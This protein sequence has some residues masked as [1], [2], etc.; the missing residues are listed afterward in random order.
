MIMSIEN[1][2]SRLKNVT[3]IDG[4][5]EGGQKKVYKCIVNNKINALKFILSACSKDEGELRCERELATLHL[6]DSKHLIKLGEIP[7]SEEN[8]YT[9]SRILSILSKQKGH[10]INFIEKKTGISENSL[11]KDLCFLQ[12]RNIIEQDRYGN[13]RLAENFVIPELS[14]FSF[15]LKLENWKRALFQVIRYKTFSEF[16]YVVMPKEKIA[17]LKKNIDFFE[18]SNIGIAVYDERKDTLETIYRATKNRNISKSHLYYMSG[19]I[20]FAYQ[21]NVNVSSSI[22]IIN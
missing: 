2:I 18:Q 16:S 15:E 9:V 6:C 8:W 3:I 1:V 22:S 11:I 7:Y 5:F 4:P 13:Y 17:L 20:M 10:T 21:N 12:N 19:K 14:I